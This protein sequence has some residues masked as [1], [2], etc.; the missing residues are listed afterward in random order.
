MVTDMDLYNAMIGH[1]INDNFEEFNELVSKNA[2]ELT[3]KLCSKPNLPRSTA[4]EVIAE[5]VTF[6]KTTNN[7]IFNYE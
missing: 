2:L 1:D 4:F 3:V 7:G 6:L 5:V